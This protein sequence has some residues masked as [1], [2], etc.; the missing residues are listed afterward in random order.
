[1]TKKY[2]AA[3]AALILLFAVAC[4]EEEPTPDPALAFCDSLQ[5]L[6]GSIEDLEALGPS[7]TVEDVQNGVDAVSEAAGEV[8]DSAADLAESQVEAIE[9]AVS[10]LEGYRDDISDDETIADVIEGLAAQVAA[11][12]QARAEAGQVA[13]GEEEAEAAVEEAQATAEAVQEE[14]EAAASEAAEQV[15]EAAEGAAAAVEE[16]VEDAGAAVEET[17]EEAEAAVEEAVDE[18]QEDE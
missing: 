10:D 8:R 17:A 1:M 18:A 16:T 11:V 5:T 14:A 9:S 6:A 2:L 3:G 12:K 4:N 7:S 15:E 13:C